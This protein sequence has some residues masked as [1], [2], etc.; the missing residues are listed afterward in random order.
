[1]N[2]N[3]DDLTQA[4]WAAVEALSAR[5]WGML[6][7]REPEVVSTVLIDVLAAFLGHWG[8]SY[9]PRERRQMQG[10]VMVHIARVTFD[11]LDL[12]EAENRDA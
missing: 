11:L 10:E 1:M 5:I 12:R 8:A 7:E 2:D 6:H 9:R 4:Q 3:E